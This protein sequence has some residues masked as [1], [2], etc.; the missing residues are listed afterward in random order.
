MN[1]YDYLNV[2]INEVDSPVEFVL[3]ATIGG[4]RCVAAKSKGA[5]IDLISYAQKIAKNRDFSHKY[6]RINVTIAPN[7]DELEVFSVDSEPLE[8]IYHPNY[9]FR[10]SELTFVWRGVADDDLLR[11]VKSKFDQVASDIVKSLEF[12]GAR[13]EWPL[14]VII[15]EC[16]EFI[17]NSRIKSYK[18]AAQLKMMAI[19]MIGYIFIGLATFLYINFFKL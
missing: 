4:E 15:A 9:D 5:R 17:V 2:R 8:N 19:I 10:L 14:S 6:K 3:I 16:N 18:R 11:N 13:L 1:P 7:F 12:K